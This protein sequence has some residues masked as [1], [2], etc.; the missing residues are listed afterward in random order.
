MIARKKAAPA[1]EAGAATEKVILR[2]LKHYRLYNTNEVAGF[3]E[4]EAR[5]LIEAGI[6]EEVEAEADT[7]GGK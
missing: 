1:A 5:P 4:E 3:S 2:F 7:A 6:A